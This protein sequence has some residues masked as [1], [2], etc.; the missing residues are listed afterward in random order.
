MKPI[1]R[2]I[3]TLCVLS[4]VLSGA[5][6]C[7]KAF[8]DDYFYFSD[9]G[10]GY[11][12]ENVS[13]DGATMFIEYDGQYSM[14][15]SFK[16]GTDDPYSFPDYY[17]T[18]IEDVIS[19]SYIIETRELLVRLSSNESASMR[20]LYIRADGIDGKPYTAKLKQSPKE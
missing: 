12:F 17:F 13:I 11:I 7:E 6:S 2:V 8:P 19:A 18:S 4:L 10:G 16:K 14:D 1:R 15:A 9:G 5:C 20:Y 3:N